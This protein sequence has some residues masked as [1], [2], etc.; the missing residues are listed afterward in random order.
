MVWQMIKLNLDPSL[1]PTEVK[2]VEL[3]FSQWLDENFKQYYAKTGVDI[4]PDHFEV[5]YDKY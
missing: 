4:N 3:M 2:I 5:I 1:N